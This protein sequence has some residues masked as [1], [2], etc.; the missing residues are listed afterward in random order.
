MDWI[1]QVPE[2]MAMMEGSVVGKQQDPGDRLFQI[3]LEYDR[4]RLFASRWCQKT[5]TC[6]GVGRGWSDENESY[7]G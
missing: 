5:D 3:G 7:L 2:P 6:R 4:K 1:L